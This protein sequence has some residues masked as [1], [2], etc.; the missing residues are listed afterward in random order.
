MGICTNK[1]EGPARHVLADLGLAPFFATVVGGDRLPVVKPDPAPLRLC[2]AE[3]GAARFV[4][5]GDSEVDAETARAAGVPFLLYT[6]GYRKGPVESLPH[7]AAFGAF[8]DLHG[9]VAR[10]A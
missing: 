2:A 9:L 10:F 4:F 8:A 7:A 1:P 5:V 3:M 6:E